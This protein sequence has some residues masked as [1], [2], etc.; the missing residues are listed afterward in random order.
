MKKITILDAS[1]QTREVELTLKDIMKMQTKESKRTFALG[2]G[3]TA[4]NIASIFVPK[5]AKAIVAGAGM[6]MTIVTAVSN[7]NAIDHCTD[8]DNIDK[9]NSVIAD[10]AARN[11]VIYAY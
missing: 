8:Q 6:V 9:V 7:S 1:N 4:L 5:P 11:G 3:A 2:I 10:A